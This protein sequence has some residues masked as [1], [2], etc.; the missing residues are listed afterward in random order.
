MYAKSTGTRFRQHRRRR[1]VAGAAGLFW[2]STT[3]RVAAGVV[4]LTVLGGA[5]MA[6]FD[7]DRA[8]PA[9]IA[10]ASLAT[11]AYSQSS[12]AAAPQHSAT[13]LIPPDRLPVDVAAVPVKPLSHDPGARIFEKQA[14]LKNAVAAAVPAGQP[15]IAVVIDDVG[16]DRPRSR[17]AMALPAPVTI[18]LMAYADDAREQA[19]MARRGGHE[20]LVHMPMEPGDGA[21]NPGPNALLSGLPPGEFSRRLDWNLSR[22]AGYVGVNNHMGSKLTSDPAALT[23]VMAA[24]KQRGLMF[25]DSRT[26]KET[27][28]LAVARR[29]GVPAVERHVFI[30]HDNAPA[31]V[32]ASLV[33][34]EE[35]AQQN[36]FAI[37]IGHPR[38][39]TLDAL[40]EWLLDVRRR[41]FAVVPLT[42]VVRHHAVLEG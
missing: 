39:A 11:I 33:R 3:G 17:R 21:E 25:L 20:L 36:G 32:R 40:E 14:W 24:L 1:R 27:Q 8:A 2:R 29:F 31:A 35:L 34:A 13:E 30:D 18:A 19:A 7:A 6:T 9:P 15:M 12:E 22:F 10:A 42:A 28:A 38:D 41:G 16:L 23:P 26:T 4:I 37:A 5:T